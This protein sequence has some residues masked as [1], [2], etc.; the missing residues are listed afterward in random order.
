M[1]YSI[2]G[3]INS[4]QMD[5][6]CKDFMNKSPEERKMIAE[7]IWENRNY[8]FLIINYIIIMYYIFIYFF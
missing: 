7:E 6:K 5:C 1:H 8:K 3:P 4:H 2:F